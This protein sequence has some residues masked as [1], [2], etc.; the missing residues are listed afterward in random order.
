MLLRNLKFLVVLAILMCPSSPEAA[1]SGADRASGAGSDCRVLTGIE[2]L[3]FS[4]ESRDDIVAF[5]IAPDESGNLHAA[6]IALLRASPAAMPKHVLFYAAKPLVSGTWGAPKEIARGGFEALKLVTVDRALTIIVGPRLN[7]YASPDGGVTWQAPR[8]IGDATA[9]AFDTAVLGGGFYIASMGHPNTPYERERRD[10]THERPVVMLAIAESGIARRTELT[11]LAPSVFDSPRPRLVARDTR[12]H[13]LIADTSENVTGR[14]GTER[15]PIGRLLYARSG[16]EPD[17]KWSAPTEL[18][19]P[20]EGLDRIEAIDLLVTPVGIFAFCSAR[21]L[22]E[23]VSVDG[24]TWSPP[25]RIDGMGRGGAG[26]KT[27]DLSVLYTSGGVALFWVD[28][29]FRKHDSQWWNPLGGV[30]WSDDTKLWLN[31]D[32]FACARKECVSSRLTQDGGFVKKLR[33]LDIRGSIHLGW[34]GRRRVGRQ[35]D[36]FREGPRLHLA[37][38][39]S[40]SS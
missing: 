38:L 37:T 33:A 7:G 20:A 19:L 16:D 5:D 36:S 11:R 15:H 13:L 26:I 24:Q 21:G 18:P 1:S 31:N 12:L 23:W 6:W 17:Q 25:R 28:D 40:C 10:A 35:L 32:L 9:A 30:P 3:P 29:R 34:I 4:A 39:Q 2:A 14:D 8:S 27:T 22:Y